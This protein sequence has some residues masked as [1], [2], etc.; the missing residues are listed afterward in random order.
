M[1][2]V[3]D[4]WI[5]PKYSEGLGEVAGRAHLLVDEDL[6]HQIRIVFSPFENTFIHHKVTEP[7]RG[8]S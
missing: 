6:K 7:H 2:I 4:F 3:V 1:E 5:F 8:I